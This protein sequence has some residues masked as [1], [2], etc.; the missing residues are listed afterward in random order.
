MK[1]RRI[2][3]GKELGA[4]V[5]KRRKDLGMSQEKLAEELGITYQQVQR[6]ENG[7]NKLNVDN[8]QAIASILHIPV[9]AFFEGLP[10]PEPLSLV[11][12]DEMRLLK[13]YRD[14]KDKG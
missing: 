10:E 5:K 14:I 2:L 9:A 4:I 13:I 6:Y 11:T 12:P 8:L 1:K 7:S 3:S